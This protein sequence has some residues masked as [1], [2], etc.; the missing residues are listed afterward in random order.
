MLPYW[1]LFTIFAAG[2]LQYE[3]R[4]SLSRQ[5]N[6]LLLAAGIFVM[7][8]IG[9]RYQVGGDWGSYEGL[10]ERARGLDLRSAISV[11]DPGYSFLNWL[12]HYFEFEIWF[13][14]LIC[15]AVFTWGLISFA[16][17]Q[18]NPWLAALVAV[19]YLIIVVAMGYTRQAVA[20]GF[21][22]AGL[23]AIDRTSILRFALY[24]LCAVAF[25]KSAIIVLP[26]VALSAAKNRIAIAILLAALGAAL[27][28]VFVASAFDDLVTNY[29]EAEYQSQGAAIRVAMNLPPAILYL[30]YQKRFKLTPVQ[31]KLWRNFSL[32]AM[33]TFIA[34]MLTSSSTAVDRLALYLL[35]L[36][37]FVLSRLP[38][39][40][41]RTGRS[42]GQLVLVLLAYSALIQLVWLNKATHAIYW[43]P[44][45]FYPTADRGAV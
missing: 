7:F 20:I 45:Q 18:P 42:N 9:L 10:Y 38:S 11:G 29:V 2:S 30:I 4:D 22:L 36:Q 16:R 3:R 37:M 35:P 15:A 23:A 27:Y 41:S 28:Y 31:Q 13:V 39:V 44:Y 40:F 32:A 14:N 21:I 26:I 25:H 5:R 34:L 1:L 19:P 43:V 24:V 17:S 6:P 8:M 33:G 12:A